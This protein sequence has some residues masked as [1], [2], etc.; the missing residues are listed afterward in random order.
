MSDNESNNAVVERDVDVDAVEEALK[1]EGAKVVSISGGQTRNVGR[2]EFIKAAQVYKPKVAIVDL[3]APFEGRQIKVR[4]LTAGERDKYEG[5]LVRGRL[6]NQK[7]DMTEL[8]IGLV[9]AAAVDWDD[10]V[11]PLFQEKDKDDLRNMGISVI[12]AIYTPASKLSAVSDE[13]EKELLG[14]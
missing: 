6:G 5:K 12:Q 4:E 1:K 14:E 9:I 10:E 3:P 8:R 2:Y 11:T 13:D 7:I